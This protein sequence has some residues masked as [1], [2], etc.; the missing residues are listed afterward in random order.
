MPTDE[1]NVDPSPPS[2]G[3]GHVP[4]DSRE[5]GEGGAA[6]VDDKGSQLA[7]IRVRREAIYQAITGLEDALAGPI[8]NAGRWRLRVAMAVDHA[9]A[10]ITE[11]VS[12]TEEPGGFLDQVMSETPRLASRVAQ[13]RVDHERLEKSVDALRQSLADVHDHDVADRANEIRNQAVDLL[14]Q[15]A[16]HRQRGADLVYEVYHVDIGSTG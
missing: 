14:G 5:P 2:S 3:D 15:L 1:S 10:R 7:A 8:G 6:S 9:V 4:G 11:H 12:Q 16:R 13:L